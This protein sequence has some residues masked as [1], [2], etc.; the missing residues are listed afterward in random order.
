MADID[1]AGEIKVLT[2]ALAAEQKKLD[3]VADAV[4]IETKTV[5]GDDG[6]EHEDFTAHFDTDKKTASNEIVGRMRDIT[7]QI[8]AHELGMEVA[9]FLAAPEGKSYGLGLQGQQRQAPLEAKT[10]GQ[11]VT[12]AG[13]IWEEMKAQA[14]QR[15]KSWTFPVD[16]SL[17]HIPVVPQTKDVYSAR[18]GS[19]SAP[20]FGSGLDIVE[21][22][23]RTARVRDLFPVDTTTQTQIEYLRETGFI[24][25]AAAIGERETRAADGTVTPVPPGTVGGTDFALKPNSDITFEPRTAPIRLIAHWIRAH[26]T[27]LADEP[28]LR[29]II[30][31]RM[32]YGLKLEEDWQLLLGDGTGENLK[33]I[34]GVQG[35]QAYAQSSVAT[36]RKSFA[37]RRAL[38]RVLVA[39]YESTGCVVN[40]FD[41]EDIELEV[42]NQG[43]LV[44]SM[45]V[46]D[47]A[48]ARLWRIPVVPTV[49]MPEG[50]FLTGAFGLGA[51]VWDR[52]EAQVTISTEDADNF[53]RNAVTI[54]A[55]ER[56]GLEVTR[57]E[58]FVVG[59]FTP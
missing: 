13:D 30:D 23:M 47:G 40:P 18:G 15:G 53:R 5:K 2:K 55:E 48:Q 36:D 57:P 12:E 54:L 42:D 56:I 37:V 41:W 35:V 4:T 17:R 19:Y 14:S 16:R 52:E 39:Q 1:R 31:S 24:N 45:N 58:A 27:V 33:G 49:A 32:M 51:K 10:L 29:A 50:K 21:A 22:M 9:E 7:T 43:R 11:Y 26:K 46:Q 34:M 38:T 20:G 6:V 8:K 28:R 3:D 59:T 25:N 44:V